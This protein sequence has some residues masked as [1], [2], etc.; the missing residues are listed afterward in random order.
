MEVARSE[1][2]RLAGLEDRLVHQERAHHRGVARVLVGEIEHR[3]GLAGM[4]TVGCD[5]L[6]APVADG[7]HQ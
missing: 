6:G 7:L 4:R 5:E 2:D 3:L 1:E